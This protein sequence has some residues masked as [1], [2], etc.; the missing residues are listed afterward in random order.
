MKKV[1]DHYFKKAKEENYPARSIYKLKE[2]DHRFKLFHPGMRVLDLGAAPGSWSLYAAERVD[3]DGLVV[4][5]DLKLP[6]TAFPENVR[7][8]QDDVFSPSR[9]LVDFLDQAA[10]FDVVMSDMAPKTTG[11]RFADQEKSLQ[12]AYQALYAA[13]RT[14]IQGGSFTAKLFMG[15][16]AKEYENVLRQAFQTVRVFKPK[17]SRTESYEIFYVGLNFR[18]ATVEPLH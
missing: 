2:I 14:L 4:A 11:V 16:G 7:F 6:D 12:L 10:P 18:G 8:Y 5:V 3:W 15:P 13:T 9:A 1:Q 17:S